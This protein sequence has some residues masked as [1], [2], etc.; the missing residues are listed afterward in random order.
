VQPSDRQRRVT[1]RIRVA[2]AAG[3]LAGRAA[4]I[5]GGKGTVMPGATALKLAPSVLEVLIR[6]RRTCFVSGTNGKTTTTAFIAAALGPT[7]V[8]NR[9]GANLP[10][11]WVTA[12]LDA[13]AGAPTVLEVDE[14]YLPHALSLAPAAVVVLLNL[15]RDQLDRHNETRMLSQ[16]WRDALELAPTAR[17]VANADDPLV[18]YAAAGSPIITWVAAGAHWQDDAT[19]CP[20]C[21]ALLNWL[22]REWQCHSCG[23][24]RPQT[25]IE[26]LDSS[27]RLQLPGRAN[28]ANVA[29]ALGAAA[30]LDIDQSA[31]LDAM[32]RLTSVSGRY[33]RH[34]TNGHDVTVLLAKNPAGWIETLD[35]IDD[36]LGDGP[37]TVVVAINAHG[38][39]GRDPSWLWD[40]P[41]EQLAG[42]NVIASGERAT[43]LAVRLDNAGVEYRKDVRAP[44]AAVAGAPED[45]V[46]IA[47]TYSNFLSVSRE[48]AKRA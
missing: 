42:R 29:M 14:A 34:R 8:T 19:T 2:R 12:L 7:T 13:P 10:A 4:R 38:P 31:A 47:A 9:D 1:A 24:K 11:G 40:V 18:V 16:R 3:R 32:V 27:V 17:V 41:F 45:P 37:G 15:T 6:D 36:L 20:Q 26:P 44:L 5:A 39:D 23:L 21:G 35:V 48:L 46:I 25:Q 28:R 30:A 22:D 43:D 33:A